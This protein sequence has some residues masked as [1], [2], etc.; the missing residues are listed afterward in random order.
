[1]ARKK[2]T[3]RSVRALGPGEEIWD[4]QLPGF[5]A[6]R[7]KERV[8]FVIRLRLPNGQRRL[9]TI[10]FYG[11][12]TPEQARRQAVAIRGAVVRGED[13]FRTRRSLTVAEAAKEFTRDHLA[14]LKPRTRESYTALLE[15]HIL[16]AMG[17]LAIE[18]VERHH[19]TRLHNAMATTPRQ[20][21]YMLSVLS[22]F[23]SWAEVK[24]YRPQHSNPT[25]GITRYVETKREVFLQD[26]D[27]KRLGKALDE[28]KA[29]GGNTFVVAAIRLL[30]FTG[31]RLGEILGLK[32]EHVDLER[33][34][35]F[36]PDSK[37]GG[38]PILLN[39]AAY[40]V[41][42]SLPR[43]ADNPYV[44]CGRKSGRPL[45]NLQKPW[46]RIRA[47]AGLDHV[48]LHDLRHSFA[49]LA[50]RQGASLREIG[51]LLGHR[52]AQTTQRY[53][54]LVAEDLRQTNEQIGRHMDVLLR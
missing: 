15:R 32:W 47:R 37:T 31:A 20:A 13:P 38:K 35:I 16:P 42:A 11:G 50:A 4:T 52:Q 46:R 22:K 39:E 41:L 26:A 18:A 44:L 7:Q 29:R 33:R 34:M 21:N 19:V 51:F 8:S 9:K 10:G 27:Y 36:L 6:R 30:A 53:A 17:R 24:G 45:V 28:E 48:R 2:I 25:A 12:L 54:H 3:A 49:S 43:L 5:G 23:M 1:M 40:E 14:K